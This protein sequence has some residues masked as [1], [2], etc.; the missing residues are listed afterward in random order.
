MGYPVEDIEECIKTPHTF[1]GKTPYEMMFGKKPKHLLTQG[2]SFPEPST[3][4]QEIPLRTRLRGRRMNPRNYT[5]ASVKYNV[6]KTHHQS[7][8]E[9]ISL[10]NF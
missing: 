6:A 4:E 2:I 9:K 1:M 5:K 8:K 10:K 3:L 7:N